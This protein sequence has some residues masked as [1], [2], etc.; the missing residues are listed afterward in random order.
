MEDVD[1]AF[2]S[3]T[4]ASLLDAWRWQPAVLFIAVGTGAWY[5]VA[6]YRR[7]WRRRRTAAFLAGV[8][9]FAW[10]GCGFFG[11]YSSSLLSVWVGRVPIL[12]IAVPAL[13][14][15]G[16][17][18]AL[19]AALRR[20]ARSRPGR[21]LTHPLV[22]PAFVPLVAV[23]VAFTPLAGWSADSTAA[24]VATEVALVL[25]GVLVAVPLAGT[26]VEGSSPAVGLTLAVGLLELFTANVP[27]YAL[28]VATRPIS[29]F[30]HR[31][32]HVWSP[33]PLHDQRLAG[34]ILWGFGAMLSLPFV[35]TMFWHW[36]RAD[37]REAAEVD[38]VLDAEQIAQGHDPETTMPDADRPWWLT[39]EGQRR[40]RRR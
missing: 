30:T 9:L 38:V 26:D 14:A 32:P 23:A 19:S 16:Q 39:A 11:V 22:G 7:H 40:L 28:R 36:V 29:Y 31:A 8:A 15:A 24:D 4:P 1:S 25:V 18:V 20:A 17:P 21:L 6:Q 10:T 33:T 35:A 34:A 5:L 13:L 2:G 27:G 3:P 12:L 37:A